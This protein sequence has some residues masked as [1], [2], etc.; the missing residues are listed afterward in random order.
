MDL[1]FIYL[2]SNLSNDRVAPKG[3]AYTWVL[4]QTHTAT[5]TIQSNIIQNKH[6]TNNYQLTKKKQQILRALQKDS[7]LVMDSIQ[8]DTEFQ[9]NGVLTKK[10]YRYALIVACSG[11][12]AFG[13]I[14]ME[15]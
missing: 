8:C 14:P 10:K 3:L 4:P 12:T 11:T 1:L 6:K 13:L 7:A 5:N 2:L 15:Y 9:I